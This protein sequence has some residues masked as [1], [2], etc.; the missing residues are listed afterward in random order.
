MSFFEKVP[1]YL[2]D[3]F[4]CLDMY[5]SGVE[6][7]TQVTWQQDPWQRVITAITCAALGV[8]KSLFD[9]GSEYRRPTC[10]EALC[11]LYLTTLCKFYLELVINFSSLPVGET[12][13][14][15]SL[16]RI[17][18]DYQG[19]NTATVSTVDVG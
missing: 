6:L 13:Q 18:S 10:K 12:Q 8:W 7:K 11:Y 17:T 16:R 4:I 15:F 9:F 19:S 14:L 2:S 1:H 3:L 5:Y